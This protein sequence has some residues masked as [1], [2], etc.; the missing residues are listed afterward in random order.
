MKPRAAVSYSI[1]KKE[2]RN[3]HIR[4]SHPTGWFWK[5]RSVTSENELL[6][7]TES[8]QIPLTNAART[9]IMAN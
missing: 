2:L 5:R 1:S 3:S 7:Y 4:G 9:A 6:A 8:H